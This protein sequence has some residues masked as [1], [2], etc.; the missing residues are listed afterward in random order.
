MEGFMETRR[1]NLEYIYNRMLADKIKHYE[2]T[3]QKL[4]YAVSDCI[5]HNKTVGHTGLARLCLAH[6]CYRTRTDYLLP[7]KEALTSTGG[8]GCHKRTNILTLMYYLTKM[9]FC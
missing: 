5:T 7:Q 4:G 3:K 6:W 1:I 8:G 9:N 2:E